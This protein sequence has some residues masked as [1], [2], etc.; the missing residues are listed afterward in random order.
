MAW[1]EPGGGSNR[2]NDP[3]GNRNNKNQGPPDLDEIL[4]KFFERLSSLFGG[5]SGGSGGGGPDKGML[6]LILI[7]AAVV[8]G[9]WG[10][11]TV[12]QAERGVIQLFGEHVKTVG[13]GPVFVAK[14]F[15]KIT[16]VNVENIGRIDNE[17]SR[18]QEREM[19]TMDENI[20]IVKY[21]V[22]YKINSAENFLFKV[23]KPVLTL[24]QASESA[25]REIV[26]R[27]N[28]EFI[29]TGGREAVAQSAKARIQEI[30]DDYDLG[31]R[32]QSVSLTDAKFPA[33][34]QAA[35]DDVTKAREDHERYINEAQR[36]QNKVVPDAR[37]QAVKLVQEAKGY[38]VE[39]IKRAEGDVARFNALL[40]EYRKA[41]QVTRDRLYLDAV[42]GVMSNSSK[43]VVDTDGGNSM[44]YLPL[45]KIIGQQGAT[46]NPALLTHE[47]EA[48]SNR[49]SSAGA[50]TR[51]D[52]RKREVR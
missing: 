15:F 17:R 8:Y 20:V 46:R 28:L 27:N 41:P 5:G 42:E 26:G 51:E 25:I 18:E 16:K 6:A 33:A 48:A 30:I 1:N 2:P 45:D 14:P 11:T 52:Y 34:V 22:Q 36:Y 39:V 44:I 4:S 47:E 49:S 50:R 7:A 23:D 12:K 40:K 19:L 31:I 21:V 24:S 37:G 38:K 3:W 29:T 10:F 13:P 9:L 35:I 32:V 43:V